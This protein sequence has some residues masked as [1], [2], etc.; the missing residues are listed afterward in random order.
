MANPTP[1]QFVRAKESSPTAYD[2]ILGK[3]RM[4]LVRKVEQSIQYHRD[5]VADA[6]KTFYR[7]GINDQDVNPTPEGFTGAD[8]AAAATIDGVRYFVTKGGTKLALADIFGPGTTILPD[9]GQVPQNQGDRIDGQRSFWD[10]QGGGGIGPGADQASIT[11]SVAHAIAE[12]TAILCRVRKVTIYERMGTTNKDWNSKTYPATFEGKTVQAKG[13]TLVQFEDLYK[14]GI[15][16]TKV[17]LTHLNNPFQSALD[18]QI[19]GQTVYGDPLRTKVDDAGGNSPEGPQPYG[20]W[21]T[22][23]NLVTVFER[24]KGVWEQAKDYDA[25]AIIDY[26][27]SSCHASCHSSRSRR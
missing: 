17:G 6:T 26:C 22:A 11:S 7:A 9:D 25:R 27:H 10:V 4:E 24:M 1:G 8:S 21:I 14:F 5:N 23:Q 15:Q 2:D 3:F 13:D 16:G 12:H 20:E 19:F 18:W